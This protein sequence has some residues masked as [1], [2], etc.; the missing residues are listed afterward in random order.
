MDHNQKTTDSLVIHQICSIL[1]GA[2][3]GVRRKTYDQFENGAKVDI[4]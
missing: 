2:E 3:I 1:Y 4:S